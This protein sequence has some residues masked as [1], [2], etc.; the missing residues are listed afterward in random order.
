MPFL[1]QGVVT[2]FNSNDIKPKKLYYFIARI[3]KRT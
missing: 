1:S 3:G 2:S